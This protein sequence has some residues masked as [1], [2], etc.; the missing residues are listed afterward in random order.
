MREFDYHKLV[1]RTWDNEI[2]WLTL[3]QTCC[4]QIRLLFHLIY[5]M[6]KTLNRMCF[7]V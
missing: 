5:S 1:A 6:L 7:E 3:F 2:L 4:L